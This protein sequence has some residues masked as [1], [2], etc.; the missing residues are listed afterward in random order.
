VATSYTLLTHVSS[1]INH[2]IDESVSLDSV[3]EVMKTLAVFM[4]DWCGLEPVADN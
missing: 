4:A 1:R 2:S 3:K